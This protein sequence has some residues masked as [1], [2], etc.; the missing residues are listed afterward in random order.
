[1][2]KCPHKNHTTSSPPRTTIRR[3]AHISA[4]RE[5]ASANRRSRTYEHH[6]LRRTELGARSRTN[7]SGPGPS[8]EQR[9]V[10]RYIN[11][12]FQSPLEYERADVV[13]QDIRNLLLR[14]MQNRFGSGWQWRCWE[15]PQQ[16]LD[17][18]WW[19]VVPLLDVH[20][21]RL[22]SLDA[23]YLNHMSLSDR[24]VGSGG[25]GSAG[26]TGRSG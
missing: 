7:P 8:A 10:A 22:V 20:S 3:L 24:T 25:R 2:Q 23:M 26:C 17:S 4:A 16:D 6:G 19:V 18:D 9:V 11:A 12:G 5:R 15:Q 13:R 14:R 21:A 1:M